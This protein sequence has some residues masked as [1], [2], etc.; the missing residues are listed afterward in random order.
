[1]QNQSDWH[2]G[3]FGEKQ[4]EVF[5]QFHR[6]LQATLPY[7]PKQDLEQ[8]GLEKQETLE[9]KQLPFKVKKQIVELE[10]AFSLMSVQRLPSSATRSIMKSYGTTTPKS[11]RKT[12]ISIGRMIRGGSFEMP[13][14]ILRYA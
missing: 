7:L 13:T 2:G 1:M 12:E 9:F 11:I 4:T 3:V 6:V 8:Q 14:L 10:N 5:D